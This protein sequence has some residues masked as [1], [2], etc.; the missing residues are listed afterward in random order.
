MSMSNEEKIDSKTQKTPKEHEIPVPAKE[1]YETNLD[2]VRQGY[3]R[4]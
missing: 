4:D 3:L 1:E 2:R